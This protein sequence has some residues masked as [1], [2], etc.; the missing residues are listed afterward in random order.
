MTGLIHHCLHGYTHGHGLIASSLRLRPP[1]SEKVVKLD[2]ALDRLSDLSGYIPVGEKVTVYETGYE[3]Q[4]IYVFSRTWYDP[5][6]PR[7][8]C[9]LTHSLL[10]PMA[11]ILDWKVPDVYGLEHHFRHPPPRTVD[12]GQGRLMYWGP[13]DLGFYQE[14]ISLEPQEVPMARPF[15]V[16]LARLQKPPVL[17]PPEATRELVTWAW[18][19]AIM[20][21]RPPPSFTTYALQPRWTPARDL[22]QIQGVPLAAYGNFYDLRT[23]LPP[24]Q[25]YLTDLLK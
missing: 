15:K 4:G 19:V 18:R 16:H 8:G 12:D 17:L 11:S 6:C 7:S 22:F 10:I 2:M 21:G 1:A 13:E 5:A 20:T 9:V 14:L 23:S 24:R 3:V 25:E